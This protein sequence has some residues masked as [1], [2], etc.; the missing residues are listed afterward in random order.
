M[1]AESDK[2]A[3]FFATL[4][5]NRCGWCGSP[6][7]RIYH[8]GLCRHCYDIKAEKRRLSREVKKRMGAGIRW[9]FLDLTLR[10]NCHVAGK[11]EEMAKAEGQLIQHKR[12]PE[13]STM[14][15]EELL[16]YISHQLLS[17]KDPLYNCY[18][19]CATTIGSLFSPAQR[20]ALI[21]LL[22]EAVSQHKRHLR[23]KCAKA[24]PKLVEESQRPPKW[25]EKAK[26]L[27]D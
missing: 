15:I 20:V 1:S 27:P 14:A 18:Y 19:N 3:R 21:H 23:R 24:S 9:K 2:S 11:M 6:F 4:K 13:I 12:R 26:M 8:S 7:H 5:G 17:R 10:I 22:S 25:L 16:S